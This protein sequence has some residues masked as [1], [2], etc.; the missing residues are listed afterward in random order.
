MNKQQIQALYDKI[1]LLEFKQELLLDLLKSNNRQLSL[2]SENRLEGFTIQHNLTRQQHGELYELTKNIRDEYSSLIIGRPTLFG[3]SGIR[4]IERDQAETL[5]DKDEYEFHL[6]EITSMCEDQEMCQK[7]ARIT[8][9]FDYLYGETA[10]QLQELRE[11][12]NRLDE[13]EQDLRENEERGTESKEVEIEDVEEQTEKLEEQEEEL[14]ERENAETFH[15]SSEF[16]GLIQEFEDNYLKSQE[17]LETFRTYNLTSITKFYDEGFEE[18]EQ[19]QS[20]SDV[21]TTKQTIFENKFTLE[22]YGM[23]EIINNSDQD[24]TEFRDMIEY[25]FDT[26]DHDYVRNIS[27]LVK[28]YRMMEH[29]NTLNHLSV[30][31]C[32]RLLQRIKNCNDMLFEVNERLHE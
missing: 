8:G 11:E 4:G 12:Y 20:V 2:Q 29:F 18:L 23:I 28:T 6:S 27:Y 22:H 5:T 16:D 7:I 25:I 14:D 26:H 31:D 32:E 17:I 19:E 13:Q 24:E 10:R 9:V 30:S 3:R 15:F 1:E 21:K